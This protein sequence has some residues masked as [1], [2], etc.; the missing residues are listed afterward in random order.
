MPKVLVIDDSVSVRKVVE[1]A[2][3]GR[4]IEVVS[5]ASGSEALERIEQDPPDVIVCDVVM[6][7]RDGYEICE[8]VK[9]HPR[10]GKTP[11]VLM[12]GIVND[13]VR[14][15]AAKA[16]SEGVLSKPFAAEDLLKRLDGFLAAMP[17]AAADGPATTPVP[18]ASA[19]TLMPVSTLSVPPIAPAVTEPRVT[20]PARTIAPA[21]SAPGSTGAPTRIGGP[22]IGAKPGASSFTAPT[23]MAPPPIA[24]PPKPASIAPPPRPAAP[25]VAAPSAPP[26]PEIATPPDLAPPSIAAPFEPAAPVMTAPAEMP[27]ASRPVVE[28]PA[29]ARP[30]VERRAA[31]VSAP[32]PAAPVGDSVAAILKQF[33]AMD[34]V[35]WAVLADRE[36]F[37]VEATANAGV[38]ADIAAALSACLAESSEGLGR[39]LGRG[40]LHGI[41]LEYEKGMIV[42]YG[43]GKAGLL[44]VGLTESSVLGK[45][46]YFAKKALPELTRVW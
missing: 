8:F 12:S 38:D 31:A 23:R 42:V 33:T 16:R 5:A 35:Q 13:E 39:D 25:S 36:G 34:G 1:R 26:P 10:L 45:V 44:A 15:R 28:P 30:A 43:A 29:A 32:E 14:D 27:V 7:D 46:R 41:I 9:N 11:V 19:P 37:V 6:P 18:A 20:P 21:A 3:A 24:T 22:S 4:Q 2:L 17:A 40:T